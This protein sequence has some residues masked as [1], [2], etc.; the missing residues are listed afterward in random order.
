VSKSDI[1]D[2]VKPSKEVADTK[3]QLADIITSCKV[4]FDTFIAWAKDQGHI[5]QASEPGSFIEIPSDVATKLVGIE[6]PLRR[7]MALLNGGAK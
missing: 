7:A 2:N 5:D 6:R 3:S 1:I 4:S